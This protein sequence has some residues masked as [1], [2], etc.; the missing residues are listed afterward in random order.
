ML[1]IKGGQNLHTR[2]AGQS[3]PTTPEPTREARSKGGRGRAERERNGNGRKPTPED[4][5]PRRAEQESNDRRTKHR[6]LKTSYL[7]FAV[8]TLTE[9]RHGLSPY[10]ERTG[11]DLNRL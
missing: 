9:K 7:G 2:Q 8:P 4:T 3:K 11:G 6:T 10:N 5:D 1:T